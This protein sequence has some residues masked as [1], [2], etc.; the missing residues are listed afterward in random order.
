ML[1]IFLIPLSATVPAQAC[2]FDR[3]FVYDP[4]EEDGAAEEIQG[5][6]EHRRGARQFQHREETKN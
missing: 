6:P 2:F 5:D 1:N 4:P 3:E